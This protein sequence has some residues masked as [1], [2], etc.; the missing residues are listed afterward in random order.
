MTPIRPECLHPLFRSVESLKGVGSNSGRALGRLNISTV[1]DLLLHM[2][3]SEINRQR[4]DSI[5]DV[6]PSTTVTVQVEV[7]KHLTRHRSG[8]PSRIVVRDARCEFTLVYFGDRGNQLERLMPSGSTR[9]VSGKVEQFGGTKQ[10]V[11]PDHVVSKGDADSIPAREP[12]YSLADGISNR[13][14]RKI[15]AAALDVAPDLDEWHDRRL[16]EDSRWPS[17]LT[18]LQIVHSAS[19]A[20]DDGIRARAMERLAFDELTAN[21]FALLANRRALRD[22]PE[23]QVRDA[24]DHRS[25]VLD[26]FGYPLTGSQEVVLDEI[27]TDLAAPERMLRLLQGDVGSGKT[28]V[29]VLALATAS[30]AGG[31]GMLMAPTDI[32][33]RQQHETCKTLFADTGIKIELLTGQD[34]GSRRD[35]I[36][37]ELRSGGIGIVVGT[38]ALIQPDVG[39]RDLQL[40]VID[41]QHK[42]GVEQRRRLIERNPAANLLM[43][44]ATP[45]P[46]SLALV[47]YGETDMSTLTEKPAGRSAIRTAAMPSSRTSQVAERLK[48]AVDRGRQAFWICPVVEEDDD[49]RHWSAEQRASDLSAAVGPVVDFV[50]GQMPKEMRV[51]AMEK[52]VRGETRVLVA[53]TVVEVGMDVPSATIIVIESAER[54]GLAQ[55]HQLRGRVGRGQD[56]S[57]CVLIYNPPLQEV[58]RQR[59]ATIR[60][61]EDGFKIADAD[62]KLRGQGDVLGLRQS[63]GMRFRCAD[64][65]SQLELLE[66]ARTGARSLGGA[67]PKLQTVRGQAIQCL[68]F[69]FGQDHVMRQS[70]A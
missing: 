14:M 47:N 1:R 63:G 24:P 36:L 13:L 38:H 67:D 9:F 23:C 6:E 16:L 50:H 8:Q 19:G 3:R 12:V 29:A 7:G 37:A 55:L 20:H 49:V 54:F 69:L 46:R 18:A 59:I 2:P 27:L 41:E 33:A 28:I 39:F 68:L 21:Q 65:G 35:G 10:I 51:A 62:L 57:A 32:L 25:R 43:M 56:E 58:A 44:T 42:F 64:P 70:A 5:A 60:E 48:A 26:N 53:T 15:M 4:V 45:I 30:G 40:A 34:R 66:R 17:W 22:A 52:F 11:H 61:T 31:Q